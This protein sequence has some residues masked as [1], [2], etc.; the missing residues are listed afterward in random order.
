[1][2]KVKE[3]VKNT[4]ENHTNTGKPTMTVKK[5]SDRELSPDFENR[6][7]VDEFWNETQ[8]LAEQVF[9][10]I[11]ALYKSNMF[12]FS[13]LLPDAKEQAKMELHDRVMDLAEWLHF[14]E[15][16]ERRYIMYRNKENGKGAFR[17]VPL[18]ERLLQPDSKKKAIYDVVRLVDHILNYKPTA[19]KVARNFEEFTI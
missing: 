6:K 19:P 18:E 11:V 3:V 9:H 15:C 7:E 16:T 8:Q 13:E 1:M 17:R 4:M 5:M 12:E 14:A 10:R 2:N